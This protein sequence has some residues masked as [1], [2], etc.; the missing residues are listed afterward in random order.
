VFAGGLSLPY[1]IAFWPPGP[2]PRFL[3]VAEG[4]RVLRFPYA[5]GDTRARGPAEVVVPRLPEGGHWTR[6]LA[7]SPDGSRLFI[8]VGSQTNLAGEIEPRPP[9]GFVAAHAPGA[10]W[11]EEADRANVLVAT[12]DG[13]DLRV[14]AT[15]LRNCSGETI[16]PGS[17]ALWCV[18]NERDGLGDDLPPDYATSVR[19]GAFYGWPWFYIGR[20]EDPRVAAG[21]PDLAG[22]VT[23]PDVLIQTHSAP[24]GIVFYDAAQFPPDYRGDAFVTLHGSWNRSKRT[25]YKVIR[26]RFRDGRPTGEYEDFLTGLVLSDDAVWGRPVGLTVDGAGALLVSEDANGTVWRISR[27]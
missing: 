26:L 6:D 10:V 16:E 25:G 13:S 1:G 21:R 27:E 20:H 12:P 15:G 19:E 22:S 14:F 18:V 9:A 3:Y 24:L 17:G 23:V 8:A 11:G 5:P 7:F 4:G 2:A